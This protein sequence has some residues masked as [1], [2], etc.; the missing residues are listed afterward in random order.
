MNTAENLLSRVAALE[1]LFATPP[2]DGHVEEQRRRSELIRYVVILPPD[3]VLNSFQR[4]RR[5]RGTIAVIVR[6]VRAAETCRPRS[7]RRRPVRTS[8][9]STTDHLPLS[10]LFAT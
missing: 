3:S 8:R 5:H 1:A 6:E 7:R 4:A 2:G 10:G 9:E